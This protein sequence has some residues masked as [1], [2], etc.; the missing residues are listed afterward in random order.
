[1]GGARR[2]ERGLRRLEVSMASGP[3]DKRLGPGRNDNDLLSG[4][5]GRYGHIATLADKL[6][7]R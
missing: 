4:Q 2:R 7:F 3:G 6:P 5:L 1:M